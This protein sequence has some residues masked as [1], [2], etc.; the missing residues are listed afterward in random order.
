MSVSIDYGKQGYQHVVVTIEIGGEQR[1]YVTTRAELFRGAHA[2]DDQ[3]DVLFTSV[4]RHA[5]DL[6]MGKI[7]TPVFNEKTQEI[8]MTKAPTMEQIKAALEYE[9]R[10]KPNIDP[11][12]VIGP[13]PIEIDKKVVK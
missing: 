12:D 6:S 9:F 8:V 13:D 2:D 1:K 7:E 10:S 3:F 4:K 11:P 5:S